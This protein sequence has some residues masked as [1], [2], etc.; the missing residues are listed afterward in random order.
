[1]TSDGGFALAGFIR[2]SDEEA[3]DF[4]LVKTD[5]FGFVQWNRTYGEARG[6]Y[7]R[8]Y[9]LVATADGGYALAGNGGALNGISGWLKQ[10]SL[11]L[12]SGAEHMEAGKWNWLIH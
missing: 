12:C 1:V 9:A 4:L 7:D 8:A 11:E 6:G 3:H 2:V 5:S 10:T